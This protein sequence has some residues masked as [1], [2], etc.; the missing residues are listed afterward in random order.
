MLKF[1]YLVSYRTRTSE[2]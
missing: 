1:G 2:S